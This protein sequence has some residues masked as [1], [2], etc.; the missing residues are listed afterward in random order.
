MSALTGGRRAGLLI[1]LFSCP[2]TASWGIGDIGDVGPVT[3]WLASAGQRVFQLL[4]LNEMAPGQQSPYSAIS[5]MAIDPIFIRVPGVPEFEALGGEAALSPGDRKALSDVRCAKRI[6]HRTVRRL[7]YTALRAAFE[8]FL[9]AEWRRDTA[10]ARALRSYVSGQAWWVEDYSLFRALHVRE[11]ER[12]WTEWP[13]E[14]QR[15]EPAAIDRARRELADEVV[16]HQYLQWLAGTQWQHAREHTHG[17]A[18]FGDLP[19]MV[20]GDSADVWARQQ[21]FRLDVSVGAPPD[22]FS[23]TGQDWGMPLYRWDVMALEDFRWLRERARRSADVFH[24]YRVDHLVGFYRTYGKLK[25]GG[26]GFFS[27]PDEP[28]QLALGERLLELFRGAGAE[29]I[30]EDLG[31]V[32]D[33]VRASLAH[34][35]IPGYRV[36]RWERHWHTPGQPFRD[37]SEYPPLSVAASGTHDTEPLASWWE[38]AKDDERRK[39]SE[40]PLI[41]LLAGGQDLVDAPYRT[42]VRDVLLEAMFASGSDLLLLPIQDA[43]G[44]SDRINEPA[45]VSDEN[46]TYRLPWPV[47]TLDR[48]PEACVR[49]DQLRAWSEKYGRS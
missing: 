18:L 41:Q 47:D 14:L 48:V 21:Q 37:P 45:T 12:P 32:P 10:R 24:G 28:S 15:R 43:F 31:T 33:F 13:V 5:A 1:P 46:W 38:H 44:W 6:D 34:L 3:E 16:F 7:K 8:R 36:F 17:V 42:A 49:R 19:F 29:I 26:E 30:A 27:P 9:E 20:D 40:L 35:G 11:H 25:D 39:V 22:A 2:S 4:P 23:A